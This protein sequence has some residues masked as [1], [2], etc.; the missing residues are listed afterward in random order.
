MSCTGDRSKP[1]GAAPP[2]E[3][4]LR[5]ARERL[6]GL[7]V[8]DAWWRGKLSASALSTATA[9]VALALAKRASSP[10]DARHDRLIERGLTWLATH[11][12]ADGGW[13]DTVCSR[14]NL[15][16]TTLVWA[17]F[18][19]WPDA[20]RTHPAAISAA[21]K[22]LTQ[23]IGQLDASNLAAKILECYETDRTFSVP[24]LTHCALA[25]RL[26][27]GPKA[28]RQ[29]IP[30]PFEL[31]IFPP[32]WFA[33]LRLPVV[34]Y[35]LPALIAVG[36]ARHFHAPSHNAFVRVVR[37]LV[38]ERAM[39]VLV[40]IQPPNGGFLEA[41]PL[42]S[43][44][45]MSLVGSEK[46]E[47]RVA[48]LGL[49]FI[50]NSAQPDGSWQIDT[51]LATWVTTLAIHSLAATGVLPLGQSEKI[52]TCDWLLQQQY[53]R[54]HPYTNAAPGGWAWTDLPGGVPDAD[55]TAGALLA[56]KSLGVREKES[57]EAA[58]AGVKWLLDLQNR[59]GGIPTFCR[60]WGKLPFD[61]SSADLTA[62]A[63]RAWGA[64]HDD[65]PAPLQSD[66]Q[67]GT[68]RAMEFLQRTQEPGGAWCPLWFGNEMEPEEHNRVYGTS[69]VLLA[70]AEANLGRAAA[71]KAAVWLV[72]AQKADGGWSGGLAAAPSSVEE[73]ALAVESLCAALER[74]PELQRDLEFVIRRGVA[75]L[76]G[77]IE[78]GTWCQPTP[79][80]FYFAKLWY[81]EEMY[82]VVFTVAALGRA[83]RVLKD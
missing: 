41:I 4:A 37:S 24:I 14:S 11:A 64:W 16:T 78:A 35:A 72:H 52:A 42:T 66:I 28:W 40:S 26:G 31:A 51:N 75:W 46:P 13:G 53:R 56:L 45:V 2:I 69:R 79:I 62:H 60:G 17:A 12:N 3:P 8:G 27:A 70:L 65:L 22:W 43:F 55:D 76:I 71:A 9:V 81:F 21:E 39:R 59:D 82:P 48:R 32:A 83:S 73:T 54:R 80:G 10:G 20:A 6:L 5:Q 1:C 18:G 15:S 34:S 44:V 63:V 61:R 49:E 50:V 68:R 74:Q 29:V 58:K 77:R 36:Y 38:V 25:G 7:R 33:A 19:I 30:L 47:H 57:L 67:L 23:R